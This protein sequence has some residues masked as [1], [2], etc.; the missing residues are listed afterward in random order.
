MMDGSAYNG[1][2]AVIEPEAEQ[3]HETPATKGPSPNLPASWIRSLAKR[4][5]HDEAERAAFRA[6]RFVHRKHIGHFGREKLFAK[7]E[8][9]ANPTRAEEWHLG[10]LYA[11]ELLEHVRYFGKT[12]RINQVLEA[13]YAENRAHPIKGSAVRYGFLEVLEEVIAYGATRINLDGICAEIDS[14]AK[15]LNAERG[16]P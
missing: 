12:Q 16:T 1:P 8:L 2:V 6:L 11:V 5:G 3:Q 4:R 10:R 15:A 9:P 14:E 13:L 7:P